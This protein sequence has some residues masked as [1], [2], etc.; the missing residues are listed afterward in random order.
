MFVALLDLGKSLGSL[1]QLP[2]RY[3]QLHLS[4][5]YDVVLVF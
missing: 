3:Q 1:E 5:I 2:Q 4:E